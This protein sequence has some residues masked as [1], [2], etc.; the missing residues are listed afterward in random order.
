MHGMLTQACR[1]G[2]PQQQAHAA[3]LPTAVAFQQTRLSCRSCCVCR[4][5]ATGVMAGADEEAGEDA[6]GHSHSAGRSQEQVRT[7][8]AVQRVQARQ[9]GYSSHP[10]PDLQRPKL[11]DNR[12]SAL[13]GSS[14]T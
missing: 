12:C 4:A 5:A 8:A 14:V 7:I 13:A 1:H 6:D 9:A 3:W 11:R 2:V 10:A